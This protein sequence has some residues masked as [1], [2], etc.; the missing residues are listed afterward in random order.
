V[1]DIP[2][3]SALSFVYEIPKLNTESG[4]GQHFL[5]GWQVSATWLAQDGQPITP[6]AGSDINGDGSSTGD[7]AILN[8]NA[9]SLRTGT[10]IQFVCRGSGGATSVMPTIA[11]CG[12]NASVVGYLAIDP[13]AQFVGGSLLGAPVSETAG[14]NS[15]PTPGFNVW[16]MGVVKN[17]YITERAHVQFR[18]ELYNAFNH[19]NFSLNI[20]TVLTVLDPGNALVTGYANVTSGSS[21]L[22]SHQFSGGNRI[23][24]LGVKLIW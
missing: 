13:N 14:R 3:K 17:T 4:F 10:G 22:N 11:A 23:I 12:G 15:V 20:P 16:D 7:R 24:Q 21:F 9:T 1:I 19:R 6:Q 5:N 8:P 18:V 2:R